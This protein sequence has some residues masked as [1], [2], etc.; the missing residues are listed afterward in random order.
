VHLL[1]GVLL[2]IRL[3]PWLRLLLQLPPP[4]PPLL[5]L[6]L[7]LLVAPARQPLRLHVPSAPPPARP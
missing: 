4:P 1:S 3:L 7:L 6:L 2:L 5:L